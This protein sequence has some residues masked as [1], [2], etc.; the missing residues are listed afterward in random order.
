MANYKFIW[1]KL[2]KFLID[3]YNYA[4][5][6][7]ILSIEQRRAILI[8]IP[9]GTKDKR[10]LK[11]W[12]PISLLNVDY[13][14]LAKSLA[15]RLQNV[16]SNLVSLDQVGYIKERYLG[17][18]IRIML[19]IVEIAK[20]KLDPGPMVMIAFE[21][22]FDTTSWSFLYKTL[23][24]FNFGQTFIHY[25]KLVYTSPVSCVTNNG[26]HT[27]FFNIKRGVRQGCPISAL[28]FILCVEV[29]AI[30]IR[31]HKDIKRNTHREKGNQDNSIRR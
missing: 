22:A 28:L 29:L 18:N 27:H 14:I 4:F 21:K 11:N 23:E 10:L 16:I 31:E 13:K 17:D 8:L 30:A 24:Y 5:D 2:K 15:I 20:N 9:K 19:D 12:R 26:F 6:N 7:D 3:S 1:D 25:I